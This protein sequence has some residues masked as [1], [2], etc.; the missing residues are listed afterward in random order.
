MIAQTR[1][2]VGIF[3]L[4]V[5]VGAMITTATASQHHAFGTVPCDIKL[6]FGTDKHGM[7]T[8]SYD[9]ELQIS[10]PTGRFISDISVYWLNA[11]KDI[12]G[13]SDAACGH[14]TDRQNSQGIAPGETGACRRTVQTVGSRLLDRLGQ[15]TWTNIINTEM[16]NFKHVRHCAVIGYRFHETPVK[17]Y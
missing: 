4:I 1:Y 11:S 6:I 12:I 16:R 9:L 13:N 5:A 2:F 10:N 17:T 7:S 14:F 3:T 15:E 8:V